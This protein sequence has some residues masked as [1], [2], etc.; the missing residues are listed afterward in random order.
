MCHDI[1]NGGLTIAIGLQGGVQWSLELPSSVRHG[2]FD[3]HFTTGQRGM[4]K[5]CKGI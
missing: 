2:E 4:V 1:L 3:I 5:K